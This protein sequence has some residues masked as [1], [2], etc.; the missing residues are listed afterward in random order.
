MQF[1]DFARLKREGAQSELSRLVSEGFMTQGDA[2]IVFKDELEA[3]AKSDFLTELL[4]SD[5]LRREFRFNTLL[6]AYLFTTEEDKKEKIKEEQLLV[7]GVIDCILE[8]ADGSYSIVDYKT[9]RLTSY[10]LSNVRAAE[11]KLANAHR[12]QLKYYALA[13]EKMYGKPPKETKIYSL[14]LGRAIFVSINE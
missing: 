10:E 1:A 14:P 3:F 13:C 12:E 4:S 2:D 6:P 11:K 8:N 7:Q 9:D 5:N